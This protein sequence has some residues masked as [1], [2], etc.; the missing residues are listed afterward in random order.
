[1]SSPPVKRFMDLW[2]ALHIQTEVYAEFQRITNQN[3]P[4]T[5]YAELDRYT[6]RLMILF[7]QKAS[8]TGKIADGLADI[9]KVHDEQEL[10]DVHTRCT[11]VLHA[12]PVYLCEEVSGF[13]RTCVDDVDEPDVGDAA[14]ALLTTVS[15]NAMSPVHYNPEKIFVIPESDVGVSLPRLEDVFLVMS[16][17]I[18]ALC[19]LNI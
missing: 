4:S 14:V 7:R 5:F 12:L 18:Y 10:D 1:M 15:D 3:L 8:R 6:P 17:L 16:G 13:F 9:L 19:K 11:T 2:P